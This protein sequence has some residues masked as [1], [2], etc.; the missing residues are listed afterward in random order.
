[1]SVLCS[2]PDWEFQGLAQVLL[3]MRRTGAFPAHKAWIAHD[4]GEFF[5]LV[6]DFV[7]FPFAKSL[8]HNVRLSYVS[9]PEKCVAKSNASGDLHT[10]TH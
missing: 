1:M 8:G 4:L 9:S 5:R 7:L 10:I 3:L 2:L 6:L